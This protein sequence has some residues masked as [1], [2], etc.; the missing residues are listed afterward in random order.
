MDLLRFSPIPDRAALLGDLLVL[1]AAARRWMT[2]DE[3]QDFLVQLRIV[4][5]ALAEIR[6][7]PAHPPDSFVRP[8]TVVILAFAL[9]RLS[10]GDAAEEPARALMQNTRTSAPPPARCGRYFAGH[11]TPRRPQS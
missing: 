1:R 6:A 5:A 10:R 3:W 9:L 4:R 11:R 8:T 2:S 7:S